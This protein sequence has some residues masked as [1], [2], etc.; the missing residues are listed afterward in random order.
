M[1]DYLYLAYT[2]YKKKDDDISLYIADKIF[3]KTETYHSSITFIFYDNGSLILR[4]TFSKKYLD[5]NYLKYKRYYY[6]KYILE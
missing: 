2:E 5:D 1:I 6:I 3:A 4:K